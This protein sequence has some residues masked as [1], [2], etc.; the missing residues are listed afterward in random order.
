[1][2]VNGM[3]SKGGRGSRK[4]GKGVG[5]GKIAGGVEGKGVG[6]GVLCDEPG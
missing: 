4:G 1:M 5:E 2:W 3:I 6:M